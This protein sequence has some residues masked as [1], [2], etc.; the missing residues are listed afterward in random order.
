M[1]L[2]VGKVA[3]ACYSNSS[4]SLICV[5]WKQYKLAQELNSNLISEWLYWRKFKW[6]KIACKNTNR[7]LRDTNPVKITALLSHLRNKYVF[8][9]GYCW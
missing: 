8:I 5:A 9:V 6:K 3:F 4:R 1:R 7:A 2:P